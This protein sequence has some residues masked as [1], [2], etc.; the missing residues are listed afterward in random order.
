MKLLQR[1]RVDDTNMDR[2]GAG[3]VVEE[4]D[5]SDFAWRQRREES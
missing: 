2:D 1:L 4:L 3:E 5:M